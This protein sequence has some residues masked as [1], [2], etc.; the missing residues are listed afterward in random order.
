MTSDIVIYNDSVIF[1]PI[2][3]N[4]RMDAASLNNPMKEQILGRY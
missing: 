2:L 1:N 3:F 4:L